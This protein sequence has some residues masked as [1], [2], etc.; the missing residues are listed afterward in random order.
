[1]VVRPEVDVSDAAPPTGHQGSP[2]PGELPVRDIVPVKAKPVLFVIVIN[3]LS[4]LAQIVLLVLQTAPPVPV[5][6]PQGP[7]PQI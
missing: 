6:V 1:M 2:C 5:T 7:G 4:G 3:P